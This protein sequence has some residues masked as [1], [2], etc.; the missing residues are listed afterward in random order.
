[1]SGAHKAHAV[2][3]AIPSLFHIGH[4]GPRATDVHRSAVPEHSGVFPV[5]FSMK[6]TLEATTLSFLG[7]LAAAML[8]TG[9][10]AQKDSE[11]HTQQLGQAPGLVYDTAELI[12]AMRPCKAKVVQRAPC[13]VYLSTADGKGFYIGSPAPDP[14]VASFLDVLKD[15]RTYKFPEAF[16]KYQKQRRPAG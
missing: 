1:M 2:D 7:M 10:A 14:E 16:L 13:F 3:A 8:L 15:G 5:Q 11:Q 9:C 12:K 4:Q 6:K